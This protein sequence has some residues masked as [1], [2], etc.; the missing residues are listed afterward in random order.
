MRI[1]ISYSRID[2]KIAH[3]IAETLDSLN[4]PYFLDVKDI[5]WGD[6]FKQEIRN[7]LKNKITH[8]LVIVSPAS[9]KSQWVGYEIG[10]AAAHDIQILPYLIHPSL[11]LPGVL[12]TYDYVSDLD[13]VRDYFSPDTA[14][15]KYMTITNED[16]FEEKVE[17][18]LA[19]EF[20]DTKKEYVIYTKNE[21]DENDEITVYASSVDRSSGTPKLDGIDDEDEWARVQDVIAELSKDE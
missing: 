18:I 10:I 11:E 19:F 17:V 20:K 14:E 16:G 5:K 6:R 4:I 13:G 9:L 12:A 21:R 1:F 2:S 3:E 7:T 8:F 15:K